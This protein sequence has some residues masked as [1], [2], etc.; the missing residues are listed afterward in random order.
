MNGHERGERGEH[1]ES[2][3]EPE[4]PETIELWVWADRDCL[5]AEHDLVIERVERL[6][7]RGVVDAFRTREWDHQIDLAGRRP[8]SVREHAARSHLA[9]FEQWAATH[10]VEL[11]LPPVHRG[12]VGRMGPETTLQDLPMLLMAEYVGEN[13]AF[14]TP[15]E[16]ERG[17]HSPE[18]RLDRLAAAGKWVPPESL[19]EPAPTP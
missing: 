14:V 16:T 2:T 6:V 10:G 13:V 19:D 3:G 5:D 9:A 17:G 12:G 11:P 18:G 4:T 7:G 8:S 15:C 1:R